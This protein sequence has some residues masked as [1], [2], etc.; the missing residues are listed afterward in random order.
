MLDLR[1]QQ[2]AQHGVGCNLALIRL[3][4]EDHYGFKASPSYIVS[5]KPALE[6]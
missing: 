3:R 6:K 1:V 2:R 4:Q 5:A